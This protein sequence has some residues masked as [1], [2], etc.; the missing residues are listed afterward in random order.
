MSMQKITTAL[1]TSAV[2]AYLN[3]EVGWQFV[4]EKLE[5]SHCI[6][7]AVNFIEVVSK[8]AQGR[9]PFLSRIGELMTLMGVELISL[10]SETAIQAGILIS[11]TKSRGLSLGDRACLALAVEHGAEVLTSD[12][13]WFALDLPVPAVNFRQHP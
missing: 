8:L 4:Q 6:F 7:S 10:N 3:R 5:N 12:L 9:S 1:D 13:A 2:L 11:T